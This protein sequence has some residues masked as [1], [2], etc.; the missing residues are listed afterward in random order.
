MEGCHNTHTH[1]EGLT[2]AKVKR[3]PLAV[4]GTTWL[5]LT[6]DRCV[7]RKTSKPGVFS[8][9]RAWARQP[10]LGVRTIIGVTRIHSD[11]SNCKDRRLI[12]LKL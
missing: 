12:N 3:T 10:S 11:R 2:S 7:L 8:D 4:H 6:Q 1:F 9:A 5:N